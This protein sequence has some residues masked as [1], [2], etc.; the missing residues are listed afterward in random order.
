MRIAP[1][2]V[3][4]L[5]LVLCRAPAAL[6]LGWLAVCLAPC[7]GADERPAASE[8]PAF[9]E[10]PAARPNVLLL[11]S[12]DQRPDTLGILK[13]S[14][15][16][17]PHLDRLA[18]RGTLFTRAVCPNPICTPSRAEILTG[19]SG[20]RN[21]V[22]DFG[23][24][25]DPRLP[26]W[27]QTMRSA[28][29]RTA[30]VGKWHNN[31]RP[32]LHGYEQSRGLYSGGGGRW[33]KPQKD[34]NGRDVTGYRGWVFQTDE[35]Q[36]MPDQ[37]IGLTPDISRRFADAAIE[38]ITSKDDS[39]FF[40]HVNFTTPHDP[41][42]WPPGFEDMYAPERIPLPR[43]FLPEHPFDH[44]NLR[45]RDERLLPW[46]RTA[47]DV[48]DE[49]AV[50]FAVISYMDQQI[51][52]I[53]ESLN[54]TEQAENT[55]VV[56]TSDHGLAIGSHGLRGKQNMYE[57]TIGVPLIMAGPGVPVHETCKAQIYLRDLYP[58]ICDLTGIAIP[59]AIEAR[60]VAPVLRGEAAAIHKR[61]FC[62]FRDSQRMIRDDRWKL[63]HYPRLNRYQLF[64]L[65]NDRWERNDLSGDPQHADQLDA[66]KRQLV[67]EQR[68]MGDPLLKPA[69]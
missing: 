23:R 24:V 16:K 59:D 61:V 27:A 36:K 30:Y 26:T 38:V 18:R 49:L 63:I 22:F 33:W 10:Q 7:V 15:V 6:I 66:M 2:T 62:Y 52:R 35:G 9:N 34:A 58:T 51:G 67:D 25:I 1:R 29:Y 40:L 14:V 60:S 17:T 5:C 32:S 41:L 69:G 56:F 13:Q 57:H 39:P 8:P 12:D 65:V 21:G 19:C 48:K 28:G 68:R 37:G 53:L 55:I 45:G 64:D 42:I 43:N 46:P 47:H 20:F 44:G 54:K 11:V 50:Y 3:V 31:G 4:V